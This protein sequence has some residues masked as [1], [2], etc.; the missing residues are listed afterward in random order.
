M[1][2]QL[3]A[4]TSSRRLSSG[5]GRLGGFFRRSINIGLVLLVLVLL[6][7]WTP[8]PIR[9]H[10]GAQHAA[11][12]VGEVSNATEAT[13][14]GRAN[15]SSGDGWAVGTD[16]V[17]KAD[18]TLRSS[19]TNDTLAHNGTASKALAGDSREGSD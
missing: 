6:I 9:R 16:S 1:S 8:L 2:T 7:L 3:S 5:G 13:T 12:L 4:R 17:Q 18:V 15:H 10:Q 19:A 11:R 14:L